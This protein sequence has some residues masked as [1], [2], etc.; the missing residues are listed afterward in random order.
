MDDG[1][2][3]DRAADFGGQF[4]DHALVGTAGPAIGGLVFIDRHVTDEESSYVF[5]S[6]FA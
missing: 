2:I 1:G 3:G 6:E 4:G 5:C